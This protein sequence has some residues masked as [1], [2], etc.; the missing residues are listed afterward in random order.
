MASRYPLFDRSTLSIQPL[1]QRRHD[2]S[3]DK[4][5]ALAA[6][7]VSHP[8]LTEVARRI[9]QARRQEAPK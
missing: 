8:E 6:T 4:V 9:V 2:L 5:L 3:A 7:E 1:G